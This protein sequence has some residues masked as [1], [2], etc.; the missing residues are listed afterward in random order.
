[1]EYKYQWN[2]FALKITSAM[3]DGEEVFRHLVIDTSV[4]D[5]GTLVVPEE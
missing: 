3:H 5:L 1:V 4:Q 2:G